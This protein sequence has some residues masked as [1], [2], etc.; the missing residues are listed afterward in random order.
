MAYPMIVTVY[1]NPKGYELAAKTHELKCWPAQ[2]Q[3]TRAGLKPFEYRKN[4]RDFRV[5]DVLRLREYEPEEGDREHG[6]W[7]SGR[8]TGQELFVGITCVLS[9]G[10]GLPEG[11]C[12]LGL[13]R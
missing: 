7:R 6:P 3:A 13:A 8:Y 9:T 10:F 11:Y 5:G 12:V 4:D 1:D 2:F